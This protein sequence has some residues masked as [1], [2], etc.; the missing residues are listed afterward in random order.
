VARVRGPVP[1]PG[2]AADGDVGVNDYVA[3]YA[4]Y[5]LGSAL[6]RKGDIDGAIQELREAIRLDRNYEPARHNPER[7]VS[8]QRGGTP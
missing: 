3:H 8:L 4:R 5:N 7:A 2:A 6:A 1:A